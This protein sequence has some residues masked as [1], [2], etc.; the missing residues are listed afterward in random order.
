[1]KY[2]IITTYGQRIIE[3]E[4]FE[5]AVQEAYDDHTHYWGVQAIVQLDEDIVFIERK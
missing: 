4:D 3:A 2:I 5:A 1:M